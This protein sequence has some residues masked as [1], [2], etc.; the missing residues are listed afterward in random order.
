MTLIVKQ[1][2][3]V[4]EQ[5]QAIILVERKYLAD[6]NLLMIS[7]WP[8]YRFMTPLAATKLFAVEYAK[9]YK[10]S[11]RT[12]VDVVVAQNS[13]AGEDIDFASPNTRATRMWKARQDADR[14][15][16]SYPEFLEFCFNFAT[17]RQRRQLPQPNQ[18]MGGPE[19]ARSAWHELFAKFWTQDRKRIAINRMPF[20]A[21]FQIPEG[22]H[23]PAREAF[24][25]QLLDVFAD[26]TNLGTLVGSFVVTRG[27]LDQED[28]LGSFPSATIA[29][30]IERETASTTWTRESDLTDQVD[31]YQS[32]H[33]L[34]GV[35]AATEDLCST[36]PTLGSCAQLRQVAENFV[37][38]RTGTIDPRR[39]HQLAMN[40]KNVREHRARKRAWTV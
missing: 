23:L 30:A 40:R 35:I 5:A 26:G 15:G 6:E 1:K 28:L 17:R 11:L 22:R 21:Q 2:Q 34:P 36:C 16:A 3:W 4:V 13:K 7:K 25:S 31:L 8:A 39:D 29:D 19:T 9:A 33:S 10:N 38:R 12:N 32:C 14:V 37:F 24:Q 20:L 27:Y 18:L